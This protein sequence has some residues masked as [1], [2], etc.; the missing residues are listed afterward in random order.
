VSIHVD[1]SIATGSDN[2]KTDTFVCEML[3]RFN[4]TSDRNLTD[5]LGMEWDRDIQAGTSVLHQRAF[6]EK[7][8]QDFSS[9]NTVSRLKHHRRRARV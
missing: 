2:Y 9:G 3:D 1:N 8:L 7:R 5:I 4:G 6:T